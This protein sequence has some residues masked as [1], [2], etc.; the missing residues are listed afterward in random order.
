M[1]TFYSPVII[2]TLNRFDH[3]KQCVDSL[4]QNHN[5]D[6]TEVF[7]SVDYPAS[8]K[9]NEGHD[10]IC[11]YLE[12]TQFNFK[13]LHVIKQ[14][15]NLGVVS[16]GKR[17]SNA[18]FLR[19]Y[20]MERFDRWI[21]TED[22]N[23]FSCCFLDFM[24]E[25]LERFKDDDTVFSVC[26]YRF[27]Y[28]FKFKDNNFFRQRGDFNAWGCAYWRHKFLYIPQADASCLRHMVFNPFKVLKTWRVS[29]LQVAHLS[30]ISRK[31]FFKV[32]DNFYTLYMIDRGMTQIMPSKSYV[33]NIGWDG[34]GMH[35]V[36]FD[37]DVAARHMNQE[38]DESSCFNGLKGTGWEYFA[39][40]QRAIRK[41]DPQRVSFI[42][43]LIAYLRRLICFWK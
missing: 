14:T 31:D 15:H 13:K 6:K 25:A 34:S 2:P 28:D 5:A 18:I 43:A 23:V 3:L 24:N 16:G 1:S 19:D 38:I 11:D 10:K 29:N 42:S 32:G 30:V 21:F 36:G 39:E 22:D 7:I 35:C 9:H 17:Y 4:N 8:E 37:D 12:N 26:G 27:Y 33:R 20:I 41:E 40:N